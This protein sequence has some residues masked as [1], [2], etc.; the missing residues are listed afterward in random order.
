METR[1]DVKLSPPPAAWSIA[2]ELIRHGYSAYIVGGW[3]RDSLLGKQPYDCDLAVSALPN[4]ILSCLTH[5]KTFETG[6]KHGTITVLAD[7]HPVEVTTFRRDGKYTDARHPD[8]VY[9]TD[10]VWEDLQ[11]RDFTMNAMAYHPQQGLLD[12][13]GG[14]LDLQRGVLRAVGNPHQRFAEDALRILR[15]VRFCAVLGFAIEDE[16][17]YAMLDTLDG[18]RFLS[19]ERIEKELVLT[20]HGDYI[21]QALELCKPVWQI[22]FPFYKEESLFAT[23]LDRLEGTPPDFLT[24]LCLFL[25][26]LSPLERSHLLHSLR[27]HSKTI[28]DV[29][30]LLE[31]LS[32]P[33]FSKVSFCKLY[34]V[35]GEKRMHS[36]LAVGE[37]VGMLNVEMKADCLKWMAEVTQNHLCCSRK[38]LAVNGEDLL[39][40]GVPSGREIGAVLEELLH[41]V[42]EE[43]LPNEP[44]ALLAFARE[45]V[46]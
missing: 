26:P 8:R 23:L 38:E 27:F 3:V 37:A 46:Q 34:G 17:R 13:V 39:L 11:R 31:N 2:Q 29:T 22:L 30:L 40:L 15:A 36:F 33:A 44:N 1:K 5:W 12:P 24:R 18:L 7:G 20:F 9:F 19:K 35:L 21:V 16:T 25:W 41:Q 45:L 4:E 6:K 32:T 43:K 14:F 42:I 10:C 28:S